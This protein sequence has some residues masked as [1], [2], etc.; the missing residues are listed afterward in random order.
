MAKSLSVA[1]PGEDIDAEVYSVMLL[2][3]AIIGPRILQN[4]VAPD[5][6]PAAI[7]ERFMAEHRRQLRRDGIID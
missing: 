2:A 7:S 4:S 1:H 3:S 6:D 5:A